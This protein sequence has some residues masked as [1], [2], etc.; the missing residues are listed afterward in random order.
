MNRHIPKSG[1]EVFE[2]Y[3]WLFREKLES[4]DHLTRE[5]WKELR[6]VGVPTKKIP[7]V[8]GEFFAYLWEDVADKA[9]KEAKYR[10]VRE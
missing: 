4:L 9:E 7:E 3:E 6:W 10:R 8:I 1:K 5:M 2:S